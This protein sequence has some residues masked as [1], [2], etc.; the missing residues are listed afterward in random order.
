VKAF[1][2]LSSRS[3]YWCIGFISLPVGMPEV[4]GFSLVAFCS[5]CSHMYWFYLNRTFFLA[6]GGPKILR[7]RIVA[8][9]IGSRGI[10]AS[11]MDHDWSSGGALV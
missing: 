7:V 2:G 11:G 3:G 9:Q 5:S 10:D 4:N 1:Y 6:S 8:G